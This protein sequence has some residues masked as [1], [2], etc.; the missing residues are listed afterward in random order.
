MSINTVTLAKL[1]YKICSFLHKHPETTILSILMP[2]MGIELLHIF[3]YQL[4]SP[5]ANIP[6]NTLFP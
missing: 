1:Y 5:Y 4:I 6:N 3:S 2:K